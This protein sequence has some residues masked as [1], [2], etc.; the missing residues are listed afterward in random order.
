[1]GCVDDRLVPVGNSEHGGQCRLCEGKLLL[2]ELARVKASFVI[3]R[4][5]RK[6]GPNYA[7]RL[8]ANELD[9]NVGHAHSLP[10]ENREAMACRISE[11]PIKRGVRRAIEG[12]VY[13]D[14]VPLE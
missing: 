12:V 1:M 10:R 2:A 14:K 8:S 7:G 6:R 5:N 3:E 11:H 4:E 9:N 13:G